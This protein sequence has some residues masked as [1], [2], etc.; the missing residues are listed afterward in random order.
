M[1]FGDY[2]KA[3]KTHTQKGNLKHTTPQHQDNHC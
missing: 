3:H 1:K 2:I